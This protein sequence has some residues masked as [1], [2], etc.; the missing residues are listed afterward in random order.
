MDTTWGN[1]YQIP[2]TFSSIGPA[3]DPRETRRKDHMF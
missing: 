2:D 1:Y 3:L